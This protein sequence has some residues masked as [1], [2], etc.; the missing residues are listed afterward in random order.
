M[1]SLRSLQRLGR[2][3]AFKVCFV[4]I[5]FEKR[6]F[7]GVSGLTHEILIFSNRMLAQVTMFSLIE[8]EILI[9][10]IK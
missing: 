4:V 5:E 6:H 8:G 3:T 7:D 1:L 10:C 2:S 9:L